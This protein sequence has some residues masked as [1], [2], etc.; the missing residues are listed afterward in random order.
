MI[1]EWAGGVPQ[2]I[3]RHV[4]E[5]WLCGLRGVGRGRVVYAGCMSHARR[6]FV[7]AAKVA[8]LA[9]LAPL[10]AEV[11]ARFGELYAVEKAAIESGMKPEE[12]QALRQQKSVPVMSALKER[13]VAIRQQIA[14]GGAL[15]KACNYALGAM[16]PVGRV[17]AG[18][19]HRD[20]QQLV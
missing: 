15:A 2:R 6:G 18:W 12:R 9:P 16:E 5:R 14:P 8:P 1:F 3:S 13:L 11:I 20:R 4:A 7:D 19:A 10:P 17:F